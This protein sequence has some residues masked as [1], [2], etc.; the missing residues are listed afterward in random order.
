M[1]E[2][3]YGDSSLQISVLFI[4]CFLLL[5]LLRKTLFKAGEPA[6][7]LEGE[8]QH[9]QCPAC[10]LRWFTRLL[11]GPMQ[12]PGLG[13]WSRFA[14]SGHGEGGGEAGSWGEKDKPKR[15]SSK[16]VPG[17]ASGR[18]ASPSVKEGTGGLGAPSQLEHLNNK[19]E[20]GSE[21]GRL[22]RVPM[23]V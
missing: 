7:S 12:T 1:P 15:I 14:C 22:S 17:L 19:A 18:L 20:F 4:C 13:L 3:R 8:G 6:K 21:Q 16:G 11:W 5:L 2:K 10:R 23:E 9:T